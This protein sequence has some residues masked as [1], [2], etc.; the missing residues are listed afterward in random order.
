MDPGDGRGDDRLQ[1]TS[2]SLG[3]IRA[4]SNIRNNFWFEADDIGESTTS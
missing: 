2:A 3:A 1:Y 4:R